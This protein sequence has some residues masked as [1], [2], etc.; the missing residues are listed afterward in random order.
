MVGG[1]ILSAAIEDDPSNGQ[2]VDGS[3]RIL[4]E[5]S[6]GIVLLWA[7]A[8]MLVIYGLYV[9]VEMRYRRV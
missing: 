1:C 7:L 2:G 8:A 5:N 9:F 6:A 3:V 4:A